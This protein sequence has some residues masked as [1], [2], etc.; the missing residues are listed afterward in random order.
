[1][2]FRSFLVL[3][4]L[5]AA[6][7]TSSDEAGLPTAE[8]ENAR[9]LRFFF[10]PRVIRRTKSEFVQTSDAEGRAASDTVVAHMQGVFGRLGF[11]PRSFDVRSTGAPQAAQVGAFYSPEDK[12]ITVFENPPRSTL[13]HEL[14]HALQDQH[15]DLTAFDE[16]AT[17]RDEWLARRAVIEGDADLSAAR[18]LCNERGLS[19]F[20]SLPPVINDAKARELSAKTASQP[21]L[22]PFFTALHSLVYTF[23]PVV[24]AREA[25]LFDAPA[26]WSRER[27]DGLFGDGAPRSTEEILR[28]SE[29]AAVDPIVDVGLTELPAS[30]AGR[31]EVV[32][33]DRLGA[34]YTWLLLDKGAKDRDGQVRAWDGDQLVALGPRDLSIP[35]RDLPPAGVVWTTAWDD[36]TWAEHFRDELA[37]IHGTKPSNTQRPASGVAADGE[38]VWLEAKGP[39]VVFV[40]GALSEDEMERIASAALREP[41]DKT[42]SI[43]RRLPVS[44]KFIP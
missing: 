8:A 33:V 30:L 31:Y 37:R 36:A 17:S 11:F 35:K 40:K 7:C 16:A 12:A 21:S 22:P 9:E 2:S 19:P 10:E 27:I 26:R 20:V 24:V 4:L 28:R 6:A 38:H 5:A 14:V 3:S 29:G 43:Q 39:N 34:W 15:F 41:R 13:V 44:E 1:M 25:G 18:F 32:E 42:L 23:G